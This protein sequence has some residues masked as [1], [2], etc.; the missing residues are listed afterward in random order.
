MNYMN[1]WSLP[2]LLPPTTTSF[3]GWISTK[4][5]TLP[6]NSPLNLAAMSRL[7][8]PVPHTSI[9]LGLSMDPVTNIPSLVGCQLDLNG[10][11]HRPV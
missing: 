1:T 8:K 4:E 6:K 9:C 11:S 7:P 3:V 10:V 5:Q 2:L